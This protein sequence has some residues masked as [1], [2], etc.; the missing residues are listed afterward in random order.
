LVR[1][2]VDACR[3]YGLKV[4]LYYSP[5]DWHFDRE[6]Q[7]FMYYG[8]AKLNP[9]LPEL[10]ADLKPRTTIKTPEQRA[11]HLTEYNAMVKGQ[12]EE[13]LT[14]YG[15]I[16][17]LWFDGS[18]P[19]PEGDAPRLTQARVR[20]L[21]PGIVLSPRYFR[22]GDFHTIEGPVL[23]ANKPARGYWAEWCTTWTQGW[24]YNDTPF[25]SNGFELG[26]LAQ[27]RSMNINVLLGIGP[28]A[29][30]ELHPNAYA[31]MAVVAEWMKVNRPAIRAG[32]LPVGETAS[33]PATAAGNRRFLFA[34]PGY[35]KDQHAMDADMLPLT[36]AAMTLEGLS[37]APSS[38][39]LLGDG[40]PVNSE[41]KDGKLTV[42]LPL[43]RRSKLPDVVALSF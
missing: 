43:S 31:N 36:D 11:R 39:I 10:D 1:P 37:K 23:K 32:A 30:G 4:G 41:F 18:I 8:T 12:V 2:F 7:N 29:N 33:V 21:Q 5:P 20:E 25:Y 40:K 14:R 34:V 13:L 9:W 42:H 24:A 22:D 35:A 28:D 38:A 3:K 6:Y 16:D 17:V 15:K 27:A 19:A 26:K